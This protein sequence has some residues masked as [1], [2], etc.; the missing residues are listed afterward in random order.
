M[1]VISVHSYKGGTGKTTIALL[2][3]KYFANKHFPGKTGL[4]KVAVIDLDLI[5]TGMHYAMAFES[6]EDAFFDDYLMYFK[7]RTYDIDKLLTPYRD[8]QVWFSV[9]LNQMK[10]KMKI[11]AI[12]GR[13]EQMPFITS[14]TD[15]LILR[16][17]DR[18][19]EY[20]VIDCHPGLSFL[21]ANLLKKEDTCKVLVTTW[22][23]PRA[24]GILLEVKEVLPEDKYFADLG[25][26]L[27]ANRT[28]NGLSGDSWLK[29]VANDTQILE[30]GALVTR[31]NIDECH[32]QVIARDETLEHL[33]SLG[34]PGTL[35]QLK[36]LACGKQIRELC[37]KIEKVLG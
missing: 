37:E 35:P 3:A 20:I 1:K 6:K 36:D 9:I 2:M 21:S 29:E 31:L 19:F 32:R 5:G 13:E 27:V 26:M 10:S 34:T 4:D 30:G 11:S 14:A 28:P 33:F 7:K 22:S 24:Y 8:E 25:F 18:G 17:V 16:L 12:L 15:E 23:R